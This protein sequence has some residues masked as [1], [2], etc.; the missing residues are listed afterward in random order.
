MLNRECIRVEGTTAGEYA[1]AAQ[2]TEGQVVI[3]PLSA[4][5]KPTGG[6]A[7]LRWPPQPWLRLSLISAGPPTRCACI[8]VK[9][10]PLSC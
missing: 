7:V 3:K 8:C 10:V 2:E 1:E 9:W 4:P 6:L 5:L